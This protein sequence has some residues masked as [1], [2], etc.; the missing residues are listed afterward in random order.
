MVILFNGFKI[1]RILNNWSLSILHSK[2]FSARILFLKCIIRRTSQIVE[3]YVQTIGQYG[4]SRSNYALL[5]VTA[6]RVR[7]RGTI[8]DMYSS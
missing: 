2:L 1:K 3:M 4:A 6:I 7:Y 5:L 8:V